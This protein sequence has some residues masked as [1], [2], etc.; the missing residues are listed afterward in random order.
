MSD[1]QLLRAVHTVGDTLV[2]VRSQRVDAAEQD[3][4]VQATPVGEHLARL[5]ASMDGGGQAR[6][7]QVNDW[8]VYVVNYSSR[9]DDHVTELIDALI[10]MRV[11]HPRLVQLELDL[12]GAEVGT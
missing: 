12:L 2:A 1:K 7:E 5:L 8:Q 11:D 10:A 4:L 3:I 9:L 6:V